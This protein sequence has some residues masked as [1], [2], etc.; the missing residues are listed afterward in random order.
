M[1]YSKTTKNNPGLS[2]VIV[3]YNTKD[4]L[5]ECL[6]SIS[7][8]A[9]PFD[10][11]VIIWDNASKDASEEAVRLRFPQFKFIASKDNLGFGKGNNRGVD[12]SSFDH[13]LLLNPDTVINPDALNTA[14]EY[15][16]KTPSCGV[17]SVRQLNTDGSF[18]PSYGNLPAIR[19]MLAQK[20]MKVL[21]KARLGSMAQLFARA[22]G[23]IVPPEYMSHAMGSSL[24]LNVGWVMGSFMLMRKDL[25]LK[26]GGF[27]ERFKMYAEDLDLC[28]RVTQENLNIT[29][30]RAPSI[31]H[32][33]GASTTKMP[34]KSDSL[35]YLGMCEYYKQHN[36]SSV[37]VYRFMLAMGSLIQFAVAGVIK[38]DY[39]KSLSKSRLKVAMNPSWSI[40]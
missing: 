22:L 38:D 5:I 35:R 4:F 2:I 1:D 17:V 26:L 25:F 20:I 8:V 7:K 33:G 18:Q 40:W 24:E 13:V 14:Y 11:E 27:D 3:N 32:F 39:K 19:V 6:E 37:L 16:L 30:L 28:K 34:I 29:Y 10:L 21:I 36:P 23:L 31:F 12:L 9:C 15:L